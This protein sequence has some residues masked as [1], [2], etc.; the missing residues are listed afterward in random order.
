MLGCIMLSPDLLKNHPKT[1]DQGTK[2]SLVLVYIDWEKEEGVTC[3]NHGQTW[4][5]WSAKEKS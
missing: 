4:S 2:G 3:A 1:I 5:I